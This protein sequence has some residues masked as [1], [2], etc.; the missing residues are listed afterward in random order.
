MK[1]IIIN[2]DKNIEYKSLIGLESVEIVE[3]Y[4]SIDYFIWTDCS[5]L[6]IIIW[7]YKKKV[8]YLIQKNLVHF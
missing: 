2:I 5:N 8:L 3:H 6:D 1:N 7:I 4:N